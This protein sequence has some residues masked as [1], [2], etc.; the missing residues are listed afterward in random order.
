MTKELILR[1]EMGTAVLKH[2]LQFAELPRKGILA[3]Q[4]VDSAITDLYLSG[5]GVY[6]D[7]DVFRKCPARADRTERKANRTAMRSTL[8]VSRRE[9]YGGMSLLLDTIET[10][11]IASV[12]RNGMLNAVNCFMASGKYAEKLSAQR[13]ISGFDLNCVRVAVDLETGLLQWDRHYED[14]QRSRQLK[15][16]MMH[17]PWHTF[18]R[19]LKKREELPLVYADVELAAQACAAVSQS[20]F[21]KQMLRDRDLSLMF[22]A[23]NRELAESFA[24][25]FSPYFDLEASTFV[26]PGTL[27]RGLDWKK[28]DDL[29]PAEAMDPKNK[30]DLWHMRVRGEL[31]ASMQARVDNLGKGCLFFAYPSIEEARRQKKSQVYVKFDILRQH[32][33]AKQPNETKSPVQHHMGLFQTAYV[34]GQAL[35]AV[36]DKVDDFLLKHDQFSNLLLG[37]SLA[38]Q[39][40]T[41]QLVTKTARRFGKEFLDGDQ[42]AA[43]GVLETSAE[44]ADLRN[45]QS[46]W[47]LLEADYR[48]NSAPFDITPLDLP[49]LPAKWSH[50]LVQELLTPSALRSEGLQMNHCVA[51]YSSAVSQNRSRILRIRSCKDAKAWSTAELSVRGKSGKPSESPVQYSVVQHRAKSNAKP[52]PDNELVLEHVLT[53]L[54]L[55]GEGREQLANGVAAFSVWAHNRQRSAQASVQTQQ[56]S[57]ER[58]Q[59]MAKRVEKQLEVS[60]REQVQAET[61]LKAAQ[62]LMQVNL[63]GPP[64]ASSLVAHSAATP[65]IASGLVPAASSRWVVQAKEAVFNS[66][67]RGEGLGFSTA[68][69]AHEV[70]S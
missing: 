43:L 21:V 47:A 4:A 69:Q 46:M 28:A 56:R 24:N 37:L 16:A 45:E 68:P 6:N 26:R 31:E 2:L 22:G 14:F 30:V 65:G 67:A 9:T 55:S 63:E 70:V 1:P 53:V 57:L 10:Y 18:I 25:E 23:K 38:E 7:L 39:W 27:P 42:Q 34:E 32:C 20:S 11:G 58:I 19:L 41:I 48:K 54:N 8:R 59:S 5:G 35:P 52:S 51:G 36:A 64:A 13:V 3:G 66:V 33:L 60:K 40:S 17:T 61:E 29:H 12:S 62:A 15:I 49:A 44:A 50:Y